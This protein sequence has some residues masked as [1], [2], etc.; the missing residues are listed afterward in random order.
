MSHATVSGLPLT[1][2]DHSFL[3]TLAQ[4]R[5]APRHHAERAGIVLQLATGRSVRE[6][7]TRLSL[8]PQR[9]RR[10]AKRAA[11]VGAIGALDDLPRSGCPRQ[12][13]QAAR[14]WL[15]GQACAQPKSLGYP[16]EL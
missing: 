15:V 13:T 5:T 1:A 11:A 9:V 16:H 10:C 4:A 12:I 2:A 14:L 3:R 6:A 7:A 8:H